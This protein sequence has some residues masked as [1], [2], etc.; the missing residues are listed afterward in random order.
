MLELLQALLLV[1][2]GGVVEAEGVV[3]SLALA[4][5]KVTRHEGGTLLA[6]DV[7]ASDLEVGH[8][9]ED[10]KD[11]GAGD[12]GEGLE[13]VGVGVGI[14]AGVLVAGEGAEEAG[15]DE[16][17]DGDL[18][19]T[20]VDELG[21]AVPGEV[22]DLAVAALEAVEPG[23]DGDGGEAEGIET[24][25]T[26]H[27]SIESGGGSGEGEGL[28]RSGVGPG[29]S[30]GG[31]TGGLLSISMEG[32]KE[33]AKNRERICGVRNLIKHVMCC[34]SPAESSSPLNS[35]FWFSRL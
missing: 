34:E 17:N 4:D 35:P 21:L 6:D 13:G 2:L 23:S 20:A 10:L 8:A 19:D 15:G 18:G 22:A 25:I 26:E 3:P 7:D 24:G 28:G 29:V 1:L 5:A 30:A 11:G 27:G 31:S 33:G 16:A 32:E 14:E 12:L 9:E